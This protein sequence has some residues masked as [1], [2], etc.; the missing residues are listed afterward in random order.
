MAV[1]YQRNRR[2]FFPALHWRQ[3]RS[4]LMA[5]AVALVA[6]AGLFLL[7]PALITPSDAKPQAGRM[8]DMIQV[9]RLK[10]SEPLVKRKEKKP[11]PPPKHEPQTKPARQAMT[12]HVPKLSLPFELNQ[13]LPALAT[14]LRL[15]A[16]A[17]GPMNLHGAV[18][19]VA[20]GQLD[21]PLTI[22]SR[23]PPVYPLRAQRRGIE[24][25]VKVRFLVDEQGRVGHISILEAEPANIFNKSVRQCVS[26][27]CFKPGTVEGMA[28]KAWMETTVRF[29]LKR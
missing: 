29:K 21:A 1:G 24:G 23:I 27:W 15:P 7:M 17:T 8:M 26:K 18:D 2:R 12:A 28:V 9:V 20:M 10:R 11:P 14:D 6:N 3:K 19:G 13:R 4:W 25:W 16:A 22:L 5:I